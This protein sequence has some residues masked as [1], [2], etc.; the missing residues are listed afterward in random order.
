[1]DF[2]KAESGDGGSETSLDQAAAGV[3]PSVATGLPRAVSE[4]LSDPIVLALMAADRVDPKCVEDLMRCTAARLA[5]RDPQNRSVRLIDEPAPGAVLAKGFV[6]AL[7][8]IAGL[9]AAPR[10]AAADEP[11]VAFIRALG[12]QA[13]SVI[14]SPMPLPNKAYYFDQMVRQDFDLTGIARFVPAPIGAPRARRSGNSSAT[15]LRIFAPTADSSRK[16]VM[17]T[18]S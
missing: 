9:S 3:A 2:R 7:A 15:V 14:R 4:A 5:R 11:P 10:P 18:S 1:M 12:D 17:E 13:V 8:V 6:L 16:P